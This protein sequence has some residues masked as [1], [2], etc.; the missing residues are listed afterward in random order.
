MK[1]TAQNNPPGLTGQQLESIRQR[2]RAS[3]EAVAR[4]EYVDY[5][6]RDGLKRLTAAVKARGRKRLAQEGK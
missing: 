5:E 1:P 6:G 2:V 3:I 4:G